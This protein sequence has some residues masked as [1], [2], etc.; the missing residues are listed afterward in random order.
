MNGQEKPIAV[1]LGG[2]IFADAAGG[3]QVIAC[4]PLAEGYATTF[5]NF[6]FQ[7]QKVTLQQ[8]NVSGAEKVTVPAGTFDAY[9]VDVTSADGGTDT[10]TVWVAKDS[11][12]VVKVS[13]VAASMGGAKV[14]LEL[15]N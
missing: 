5:R 12:K 14:T 9:R 7:T 4:L 8:L 2:P 13:A 15:T 1:D 6:D 11:H 3:E 10:K